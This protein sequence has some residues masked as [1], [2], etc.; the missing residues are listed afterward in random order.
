MRVTLNSEVLELYPDKLR[1]IMIPFENGDM[2][3]IPTEKEIFGENI[4]GDDHEGE[5]IKQFECMKEQ[6]NRIA[7]QGSKTNDW[8]WYWL[9][10]VVANV[11]FAVCSRGGYASFGSAS[12]AH[13]VRPL[14]R[15]IINQ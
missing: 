5:D 15:I 7:F 10:N 8:E 2:L 11:S 3:R 9:Q 14:L 13:G 12:A 6:R 1:K 4:N